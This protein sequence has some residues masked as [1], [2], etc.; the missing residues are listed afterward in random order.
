MPLQRLLAPA[1]MHPAQSIS[2]KDDSVA[3]D[4]KS[5]ARASQIKLLSSGP[6]ISPHQI[7]QQL[8]LAPGTTRLLDLDRA[9]DITAPL[10]G[11]LRVAR[12]KDCP[13]FTA[14]SYVWGNGSTASIYCNGSAFTITSNCKEALTSLRSIE[15]NVC[16]WVDSICVNQEDD[17]EKDGQIRIMGEIS[18]WASTTWIWLGPGDDRC[19]RAIE[20]LK[21][22]SELR[23]PRFGSPWIHG[24]WGNTVT[25]D[26]ISCM[27]K[28]TRFVLQ[29]F[30]SLQFID[31]KLHQS[32]IAALYTDT[33]GTHAVTWMLKLFH[34]CYLDDLD[35]LLGHEWLTR[36]WTFQEV[37]LASNPML[38]CGKSVISWSD[39]LRSLEFYHD[40][41]RSYIP[42][43]LGPVRSHNLESWWYLLIVW[44]S[45]SR[46]T[47]WHGKAMRLLPQG[48]SHISVKD[49]T[50]KYLEYYQS[51]SLAMRMSSL[52]LTPVLTLF[53]WMLARSMGIQLNGGEFSWYVKVLMLAYLSFM[54]VSAYSF[55]RTFKPFN[56]IPEVEE[57]VLVGM[58]KA[59]RERN[60]SEP[61]DKAFGLY[62]VLQAL[63]VAPRN[64][65]I[66]DSTKPLGEVYYELF[67]D[68]L[69]W[70]PRL[71][72]LLLDVG[73]P[74]P[75]A[76]SWVPDWST[77]RERSWIQHNVVY[78]SVTSNTSAPRVEI[79]GRELTVQGN[80]LGAAS[81]VT[82]P[83][84]KFDSD[85]L[86]IHHN[87]TRQD[88][89]AV[90]SQFSAW[91][92]V[93][94][95]NVPVS[96][97]YE[98]LSKA[99]LDVLYGRVSNFEGA[100]GPIFNKWRRILSQWDARG[101]E[102]STNG[103]LARLADDRLAMEFTV[104]ICNTLFDKRG[105]FFSID[106]HIG[107]GPLNMLVSDKIAL[108]NGVARPLILREDASRPGLYRVIGPAFVCGF[109]D[110]KDKPPQGQDWGSITLI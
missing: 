55:Q 103:L 31:R 58:L 88:L 53:P 38:V 80:I 44:T 64:G 10:S 35:H 16:I 41:S 83:F 8:P 74:I 47:R 109:T 1:A 42:R 51:W 97:V 19:T 30:L 48:R 28:S 63:E 65:M 96:P 61:K 89:V 79:C 40:R 95:Q 21:M 12:L 75:H 81:F 49:Y 110:L 18:Q 50:A 76:P 34:H 3:I 69:L 70:N 2:S 39:L 93:I 94:S 77:L 45:I 62:G 4:L 46:P 29:K 99:I 37:V 105:L 87:K 85:N 106:G 67:R 71:V 9:T 73:P 72:C 5:V 108:L 27:V 92:E 20:S 7:Y 14:L 24:R 60:S 82:D 52:V 68:L 22:V 56:H 43:Y 11:T 84:I 98:S 54:G 90:I 100:D 26:R 25:H 23:P 33:P 32:S 91:L 57:A 107:S 59:L 101:N 104:K 15:E 86:N 13:N 78:E 6:S 102:A 17:A 36:V 66:V